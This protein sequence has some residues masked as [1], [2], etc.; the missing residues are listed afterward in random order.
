[1]DGPL[2]V[3]GKLIALKNIYSQFTFCN[4]STQWSSCHEHYTKFDTKKCPIFHLVKRNTL[5]CYSPSQTQKKSCYSPVHIVVFVHVFFFHSA[6]CCSYF[7]ASAQCNL[8]KH[9][10]SMSRA[11]YKKLKTRKIL[12]WNFDLRKPLLR[13]NRDF[14]TILEQFQ[15][16]KKVF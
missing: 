16:E 9:T 15:K 8:P 3:R 5:L 10:H 14:L 12:Q 1:M 7:V 13:K 2:E 6:V 11:K 4:L